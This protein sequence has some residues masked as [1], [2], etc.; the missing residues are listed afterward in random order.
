MTQIRFSPRKLLAPAHNAVLL[1]TGDCWGK[2]HAS[3]VARASRQGS[4]LNPVIGSCALLAFLSDAQS[5]SAL[6][7][8]VAHRCGTPLASASTASDCLAP[9][10]EYRLRQSGAQLLFRDDTERERPASDFGDEARAFRTRQA[11]D[12]VTGD[13]ERLG[14]RPPK[15][16]RDVLAGALK[17]PSA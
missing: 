4:R 9:R 11:F 8:R 2:R 6:P 3:P 7:A 12:I 1:I 10:F 14:G 17:P 13:V 16:L 15:P 5:T